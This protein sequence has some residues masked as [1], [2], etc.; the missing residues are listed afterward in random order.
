MPTAAAA[1]ARFCGAS[2]LP[3]TPAEELV[4][5]IS[6]ASS[7]GES[8]TNS[9]PAEASAVPGLAVCPDRFITNDSASTVTMVNFSWTSV[10]R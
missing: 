6:T 9:P 2:I 10:S 1:T 5:A 7:T 8:T 4:A 3:I